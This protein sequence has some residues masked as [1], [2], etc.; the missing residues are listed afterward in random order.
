[1]VECEKG[2]LLFLLVDGVGREGDI[3]GFGFVVGITGEAQFMFFS[4]SSA[5]LFSA[6]TQSIRRSLVHVSYF[7]ECSKFILGFLLAVLSEFIISLYCNF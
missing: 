1:M 3:R 5:E 6:T 7:Q 2:F 4:T